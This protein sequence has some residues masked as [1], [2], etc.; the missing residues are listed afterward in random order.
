MYRL[1]APGLLV[2]VLA[3]VAV[4]CGGDAETETAPPPAATTAT[5]PPSAGG[6][7]EEEGVRGAGGAPPAGPS[8]AGDPVPDIVGTTLDGTSISLSDYRGKKVIVHL[9]SS[10]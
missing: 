3:F 7:G 1:L 4:G 5:Q 10:W 2:V 8:A 6:G 9:W